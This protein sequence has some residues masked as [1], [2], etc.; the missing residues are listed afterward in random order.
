MTR[1][2][3][4]AVDDEPHMLKQME[5]IITEKTPFQITTTS[6]SLEVPEI[7]EKNQFDLI[8]MDLKMPGMDGLDLLRL[9]KENQR[10]EE[11]VMI[12]AFGSLETAIE[13]LSLGV[14]NYIIKPFKK[15]QIIFTVNR[16][17]RWQ[18][19]KREAAKMEGIFSPEPCERAR[20]AFEREY[21]MH[22]LE[23]CDGDENLTEECSDLSFERIVSLPQGEA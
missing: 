1:Q 15:E 6:N 14:W 17:M 21:V 22:L 3:I 9:V 2:T 7:L 13:A 18:Q 8:L 5:R 16:A 12:T 20:K 4:L 19:M 11:V 10:L 23:R